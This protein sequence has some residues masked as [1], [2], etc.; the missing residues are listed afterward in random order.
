MNRS[1][2]ICD[3]LTQVLAPSH[4]E[5]QDDSAKHT[6]HTGARPEGQTHYHLII[7]SDKF[8]GRSKVQCHQMIYAALAEEFKTGLHALSID[9]QAK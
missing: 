2:R 1:E 3:I 5:L 4:L 7:A 9:V 8:Q 6:G